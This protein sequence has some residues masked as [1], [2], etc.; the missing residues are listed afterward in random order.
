MRARRGFTLIEIMMVTAVIAILASLAIMK[1]GDAK[2]NAYISAMKSDLSGMAL[3]AE[4]VYSV[5]RTY[6]N[7]KAPVPT[8]GITLTFA[9]SGE[10]WT[11]TAAH[12]FLPGLLCTLTTDPT[13][14]VPVTSAPYC[15]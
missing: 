11:A 14:G 8:N 4:S 6:A 13:A 2:R 15:H 9:P 12:E 7:V 1:F 10:A 3:T 5:E